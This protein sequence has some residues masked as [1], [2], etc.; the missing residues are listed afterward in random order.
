M[1]KTMGNYK[2]NPIH[3]VLE[4]I[5]W[6]EKKNCNKNMK[7]SNSSNFL[8]FSTLLSFWSLI[9]NAELDSNSSCLDR[10]NNFGTI[11]SKKL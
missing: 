1:L 4:R 11:S 10:L 5:K 8:S 3:K 6:E 7:A 2:N 9:C